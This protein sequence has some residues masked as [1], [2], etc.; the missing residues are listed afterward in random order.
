MGIRRYALLSV[1][2]LFAVGLYVYSFN[3]NSYALSIYKFSLNL[4]IAVWI[5]VP[6]IILF[7]ASISHLMYY[8]IKDFFNKRAI[9]KDYDTFINVTKSSIFGEKSNLKFKT[10][11]FKTPG[12]V[13]STLNYAKKSDIEDLENEDLKECYRIVDKI[14]E[15]EPEDIK[16]YKI[17]EDNE[18]FIKNEENKLKA[19]PKYAYT[20][21]KKCSDL[22]SEICKKAYYELLN[23]ATFAEIKKYSFPI[24][25]DIFRRMMERY[26]DPEDN[27]EIDIASMKQMLEQF[28]ANS[29]DYLELAEEIRVRLSPDE[30]I[31][32]F[33]NLYNEKG[34]IAANAY[35]FTLYE[36]QMID[37]V[38]E[39][40]D[41]SDEEDFLKFKTLL[42]LRDHGKNI[43]TVKFLKV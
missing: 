15:G 18:L 42:F 16:K 22:E 24:D 36:L 34:Q 35:I 19:D 33:S 27:F 9:K 40:L 7:I 26:L 1:I 20:I 5:I 37:K 12:F 32:L 4:P 38:R 23:I 41:N 8:S 31:D 10:D 11:F 14:R 29:E 13:L 21:L 43:D 3:G 28:N 17:S 6:S 30:L 2:Y 39:I 25:K